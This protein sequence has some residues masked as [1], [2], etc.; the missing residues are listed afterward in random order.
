[1]VFSFK[2][3]LAIAQMITI[4]TLKGIIPFPNGILIKIDDPK[5]EISPGIPAYQHTIK[6]IQPGAQKLSI[7]VQKRVCSIS[8]GCVQIYKKLSQSDFERY[9][10]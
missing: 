7:P 2:V 9:F 1:M 8:C 3:I 10:E 5:R 4:R 6:M